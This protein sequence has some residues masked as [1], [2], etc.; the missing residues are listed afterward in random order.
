ML[1][2]YLCIVTA[3]AYMDPWSGELRLNQV[4]AEFIEARMVTAE[5]RQYYGTL[6]LTYEHV[7]E[8]MEL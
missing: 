7:D 1:K 6:E 8:P 4:L 2:I 3:D 5:D